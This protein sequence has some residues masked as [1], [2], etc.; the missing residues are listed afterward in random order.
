MNKRDILIFCYIILF[1]GYFGLCKDGLTYVSYIESSNGLGTPTLDGG[2]TEVRMVDINSDGNIDLVSVGDHG[3]PYVNTSE[4]GVM[5]WFGNGQGA[6]SVYQYGEFGYGGVAVGDLNNDGYLDVAYGIHHNYS[7]TDLGD[8]ILEAALGDGTGQY[9]Q[10]WDDN[11]GMDGQT[12]GMFTTD[13]ADIDNDGDLDLGSISFGCC[14]GIHIYRNNFNGTWTRTYGFLGGNSQEHFAFGDVNCDG[15]SD[16]VVGHQYGTVYFGDGNGNFINADGNLPPAGNYGREGVSI[17]DVNND[18]CDD[19]AFVSSGGIQVWAW[20]GNN[21]WINMSGSLPTSGPYEATKLADMNM[22]G[23]IDLVAFGNS[24][25][26]VWLGNGSG[27]WA[28][29]AQFNTPTYGYYAALTAGLDADHNGYPD[30]AI[31]SDEGTWLNHYNHLRFF[32]EASTPTS[33][34]IYPVNPGPNKV[35]YA[36][37]VHIINWT[38]SIPTGYTTPRVKLELSSSGSNGPWQVIDTNLAE[39]GRYQ[40]HLSSA[41]PSTTNAYIRYT[42]ITDQGSSSSISFSPFTIIGSASPQNPA[43]AGK[44]MTCYKDI[45]GSITC[46]YTNGGDCTTDNTIYYG[47][48]TNVSTYGYNGSVCYIGKSGSVTFD[49]GDGSWFWVIVSNNGSKEGSYG[50]NSN[51]IER[52][53][54]SNIG[55]CDYPQD[56]TNTC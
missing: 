43:E 27:G 22:D 55:A 8:Q 53:E 6:W 4:H 49:L 31:V 50:K 20:A 33:L 54:A 26:T 19:I 10:A 12:W 14:D 35:L 52:P 1:Y 17:G 2:R 5:V 32:K 48:I 36:G 21:T 11:L 13:L 51:G 16:F 29:A 23:Y 39:N 47:N 24:T 42:I 28:Q 41:L 9:W 34:A 45:A 30:I 46:N 7:G 37:S 18:G 38:A 40:W 56:L 44:P 25:C 3:N 15:L